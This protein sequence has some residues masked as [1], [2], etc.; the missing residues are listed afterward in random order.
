MVYS[1]SSPPTQLNSDYS[2]SPVSLTSTAMTTGMSSQ[3]L[4]IYSDTTSHSL[5]HA[6]NIE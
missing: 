5:N 6:L 4:N 1:P 3:S 2:D